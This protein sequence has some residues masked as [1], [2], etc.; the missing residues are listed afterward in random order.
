MIQKSHFNQ[1]RVFLI[2]KR[3]QRRKHFTFQLFFPFSQ[4]T[5]GRPRTASSFHKQRNRSASSR[6]RS[7]SSAGLTKKSDE[8]NKQNDELNEAIRQ[9]QHYMDAQARKVGLQQLE[10]PEPAS[11][12]L[13]QSGIYRNPALTNGQ[14]LYLLAK[15][16][17]TTC[18][19]IEFDRTPSLFCE[20]NLGLR[21]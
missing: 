17:V 13:R 12:R 9:Y 14:K 7:H 19:Q 1:V 4:H 16:H 6:P 11:R 2:D 21:Y 10:I 15:C 20:F 8:T 18:I 3:N 5:S